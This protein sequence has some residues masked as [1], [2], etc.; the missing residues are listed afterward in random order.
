MSRKRAAF[1]AM[2]TIEPE[3]RSAMPAPN[4]RIERNVLVRFDSTTPF[5]SSSSVWST[6]VRAPSRPAGQDGALPREVWLH[7][8]AHG[9]T[10]AFTAGAT[11]FATSS[12]VRRSIGG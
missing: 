7:R 10:P 3:P 1:D 11:D 6:G 5:H 12:I 9:A 4:S 2:V 8:D